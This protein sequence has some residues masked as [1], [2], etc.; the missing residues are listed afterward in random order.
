MDAKEQNEYISGVN[1]NLSD[2]THLSLIQDADGLNASMYATA[3]ELVNM[4]RLA[5]TGNA[6]LR[7]A[8]TTLGVQFAAQD[9]LKFN[10]K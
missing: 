1:K 2:I 3:S 7:L 5:A 4:L 9:S 8:I 6:D 10:F